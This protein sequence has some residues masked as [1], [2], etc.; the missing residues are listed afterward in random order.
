MASPIA[1]VSYRDYDGPLFA[2]RYRWWVIAKQGILL[3][4]KKRN[5]QVLSFV[6]AW[7]YLAMIIV[8]FFV[9]Q[10]GSGGNSEAGNRIMEGIMKNV[11]WKDQFLHGFSFAQLPLLLVTLVLGAGAI[12]ND[13]RSRALL[14]YLSRPCTKLDYLIGKFVGIFIP[15]FVILAVPTILFYG[16]CALSFNQYGFLRDAPWLLPQMLVVIL[17]SAAFHSALVLAVSSM[18]DQGRVAGATY[19]AMYFITN[20]FT[21]AMS[22]TWATADGKAPEPVKHLF[23]GSIDGLQIGFCKAILDTRGSRPFVGGQRGAEANLPVPAPPLLAI[24]LILLAIIAGSAFLTWRR[25][26]AVEVVG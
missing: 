11:V 16:Y 12:A 8:L 1:D 10:G 25:I 26:R 2:A 19:A 21:V 5:L 17:M 20:F 22:I 3:A 13:N 4:S 24:S 9:N 18:F 6:S 15:I 23:Y 7:Y 14:V